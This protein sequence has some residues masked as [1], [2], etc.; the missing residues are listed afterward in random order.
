MEQKTEKNFFCFLDNSS[1][2]GCRKVSV[3]PRKYL[4]PAVN[5]LTKGRR[6][7]RIVK[8]DNFKVSFV[9]SDEEI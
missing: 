8:R 4:S 5:V 9:Q 6:T 1:R 2:I 7:S 3:L